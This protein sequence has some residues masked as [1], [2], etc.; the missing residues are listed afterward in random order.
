MMMYPEPGIG[1]IV[2]TNTDQTNM[3]VALEIAHRALG[4]QI[5]SIR[6]AIHFKYSYRTEW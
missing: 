6:Q 5:E 2:C 4:G 1:V 3:D